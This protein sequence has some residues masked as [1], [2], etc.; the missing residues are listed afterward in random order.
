[1]VTDGDQTAGRAVTEAAQTLSLHVL[2]ASKG[3]PTPLSGPELVAAVHQS[4]HSPLIV[5]VDDRG[6]SERGPGEEALK[7]LL[8][9]EGIQVL[10]V[11]AVAS[12]T[13]GVAGVHPDYSIEAGGHRVEGAVNKEGKPAGPVLRGDTVDVL[14]Q[15]EGEIPIIG[16]GDPGKMRGQDRV[17]DGVPTTRAALEAIL[18][19]S[20]QRGNN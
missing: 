12:H 20:E 18:K 6:D 13:R 19:R 4:E 14:D 5:M 10:G 15:V 3:N 7:A 9:D 1:V 8:N 2:T 11:V 16:L 17:S